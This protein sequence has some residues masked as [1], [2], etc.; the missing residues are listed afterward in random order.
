MA[1]NQDQ[2]NQSNQ[3]DPLGI[4]E[5]SFRGSIEKLAKAIAGK[6]LPPLAECSGSVKLLGQAWGKGKIDGDRP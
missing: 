2:N 1:E 3:T 4:W 5:M 6:P